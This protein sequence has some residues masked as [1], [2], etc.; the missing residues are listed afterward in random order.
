[1]PKDRGL[2][3]AAGAKQVERYL[4]GKNARRVVH[5]CQAIY[6][7]AFYRGR[8]VL[9]SVVSGIDQ[10]LWRIKAKALEPYQPFFYEAPIQCQN[11]DMMA[12]LARKTRIPITTG[13]RVFTKWGLREILEKK[14]ASC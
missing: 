11:V 3:R 5:H 6:R 8:P 2:T 7:H 14:A 12:K 9:T 13:E 1:M 10:A 4:L